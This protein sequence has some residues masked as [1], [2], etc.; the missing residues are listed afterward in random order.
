[1]ADL[2]GVD[3]A[4]LCRSLSAMPADASLVAEQI[5]R[6][7]PGPSTR[8]TAADYAVAQVSPRLVLI[9][10]QF[11]ELFT[12]GE[13][14]DGGRAELEAFVAALHAAATKSVSSLGAGSIGG[15]CGTRRF[16]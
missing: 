5:V 7:A 3:P 16:P 10:D 2:A 9:V 14:T 4:S 8:W 6:A 15:G 12:A 11:E 1:L 13:D